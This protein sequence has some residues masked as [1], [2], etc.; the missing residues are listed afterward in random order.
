MSLDCVVELKFIDLN[1]R[2]I[3]ENSIIFSTANGG[4]E[5]K[6]RRNKVFGCIPHVRGAQADAGDR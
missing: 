5:T 4:K 1:G 6:K 2:G 3:P